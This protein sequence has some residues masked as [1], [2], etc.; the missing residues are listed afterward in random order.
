MPG[1]PISDQTGEPQALSPEDVF[2]RA[3]ALLHALRQ[4]L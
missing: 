4:T 3:Q 1:I 2:D